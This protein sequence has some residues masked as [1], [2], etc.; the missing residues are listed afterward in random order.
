MEEQKEQKKEQQNSQAPTE[1]NKSQSN[2]QPADTKKIWGVVGYIFPILFFVPLI[3]D[4]LKTNAYS[5]FHANQQLVLLLVAIVIN[6]IGGV[7][8]ILGWFIILP[9]GWIILVIL[10]IMGV[11]NASKETTKPLP[12]IGGIHLIK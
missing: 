7:I 1:A 12:I 8:P 6:I 4:D 5:K 9:I 10:A 3:M 11:I 2:D